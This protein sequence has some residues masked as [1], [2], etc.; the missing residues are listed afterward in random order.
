MKRGGGGAQK[1]QDRATDHTALLRHNAR[2]LANQIF[3]CIP[4]IL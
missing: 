2:A 3:C 1:E 4:H